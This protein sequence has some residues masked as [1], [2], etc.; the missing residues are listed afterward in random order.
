MTNI[1]YWNVV[2]AVNSS[3]APRYARCCAGGQQFAW[4]ACRRRQRS[5][6]CSPVTLHVT[7]YMLHVT[8]MLMLTMYTTHVIALLTKSSV[9]QPSNN[10]WV[11]QLNGILCHHIRFFIILEPFTPMLYNLEHINNS[12]RMAFRRIIVEVPSHLNTLYIT[13]GRYWPYS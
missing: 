1:Q 2:F 12:Y 11:W 8:H 9:Y 6:I 7:C 5:S 10:W 3:K 13:P 4:V